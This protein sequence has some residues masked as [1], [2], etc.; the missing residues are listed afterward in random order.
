[1]HPWSASLS[2]LVLPAV[3]LSSNAPRLLVPL[4]LAQ[5]LLHLLAP[6][7]LH[8]VLLLAVLLG[9]VLLLAKLLALQLL[10]AAAVAVLAKLLMALWA[11]AELAKLLLAALVVQVLA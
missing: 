3:R 5:A 1:M 7:S 4:L 9:P 6:P 11:V 8:W 10:L 2:L